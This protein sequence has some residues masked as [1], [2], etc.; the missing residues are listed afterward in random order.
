MVR[1]RRSSSQHLVGLA[2]GVALIALT[3]CGGVRSAPKGLVALE[4]S[5]HDF[6]NC[7]QGAS[8]NHTFTLVNTTKHPLKVVGLE[9]SCSCLVADNEGGLG[10]AMLAPGARFAV[11]VRFSP[12]VD[13]GSAT[14]TV[15]VLFSNHGEPATIKDLRRLSLNVRANVQPDYRIAPRFL[16]FGEIDGLTAKRTTRTITVTPAAFA[17]VQVTDVRTTCE[18]MSARLVPSPSGEPRFAVEVA[19]VQVSRI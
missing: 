17:D 4:T 2:C 16:D 7:R 12:A 6:G 15:K 11:P 1:R 14:G 19:F 10:E 8:L 13:E 3:G 18:P 9:T 5:D